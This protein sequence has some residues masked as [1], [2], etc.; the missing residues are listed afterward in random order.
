MLDLSKKG[1]YTQLMS[2]EIYRLMHYL[3]V[4]IFVAAN[5]TLFFAPPLANPKKARIAVG[6]ASFLILVGGM[7]LIL[8]ALGLTHG[9]GDPWPWWIKLK[10]ILWLIVA[11]GSPI[12]DK[13]L[14]QDKRACAGIV[15][16]S[17]VFAGVALAVYKPALF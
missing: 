5:A 11:I 9:S 10:L 7:G 8:R 3:A 15:I 17:L 13:R 6:I 2:E 14:P 12:L 4:I 1:V 16:L